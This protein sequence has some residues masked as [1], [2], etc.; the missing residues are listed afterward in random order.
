MPNIEN[1][2]TLIKQTFCM[3]QIMSLGKQQF[4]NILKVSIRILKI[5]I[6]YQQHIIELHSAILRPSSKKFKKKKKSALKK[7]VIFQEME[8]SS[9]KIKKFLIFQEMEYSGNK[10]INFLYFFKRKFF[11]Y[12]WKWNPLKTSYISGRNFLRSK[13]EKNSLWKNVLCFGKLN[14]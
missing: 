12:F 9:S 13:D 8:L 14:F 11:F 3:T 10:T 2:K 5:L 4:T 1:L 7:S 6:E